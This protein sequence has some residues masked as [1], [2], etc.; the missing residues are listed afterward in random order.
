MGRKKAEFC[1][2]YTAEGIMNVINKKCGEE[3]YLKIPLFSGV[4]SRKAQV[5]AKHAAEGM[6]NAKIKKCS[7]EGYLTQSTF[8]EC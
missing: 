5:C 1:S 3:G 8:G 6:V 2:K 4:G 7:H